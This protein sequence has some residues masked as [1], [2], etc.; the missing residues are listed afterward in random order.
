MYEYTRVA[1]DPLLVIKKLKKFWK[2]TVKK[3]LK[4]L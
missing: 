4:K 1:R 2:I 3:Y